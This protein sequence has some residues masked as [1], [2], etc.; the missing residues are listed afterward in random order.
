ME[1]W[2]PI[3][4]SIALV[5]V[6][7]IGGFYGWRGKK[8]EVVAKTQTDVVQNYVDLVT[9]YRDELKR[10][11]EKADLLAARVNDLEKE[12]QTLGRN[13]KQVDQQNT[14]LARANLELERR[15]EAQ[16]VEYEEAIE[17]L[18]KQL[19]GEREI[20]GSFHIEVER[21]RLINQDYS[22]RNA[23]LIILLKERCGMSWA[24]IDEY[25]ADLN[26]K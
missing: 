18:T 17:R 11:Q 12:V 22:L 15:N 2:V 24:Q 7:L 5:I 6:A 13:F 25:L 16:R 19:I 14:D 4:G 21:I 10:T 8:A 1:T 9:T 23:N 20:N 3:V 26:R